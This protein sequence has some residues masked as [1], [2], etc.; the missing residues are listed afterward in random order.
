MDMKVFYFFFSSRRR[1]TRFKCDWSSDVCSSD[2]DA[3][4]LRLDELAV[5]QMDGPQVWLQELLNWHPTDTP[6]H[7]RDLVARYRAFGG[8]MDEYLAAL[9]ACI[10]DGR[11]APT[12]AVER[13]I[14]QLE[15]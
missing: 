4:R 3:L 12:V 2:L 6:E 8:F 5:D 11:T 14:A 9:R 10:R 7:V 13:V 1:H 15:T